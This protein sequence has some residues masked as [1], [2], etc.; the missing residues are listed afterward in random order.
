MRGR[1][2]ARLDSSSSARLTRFAKRNET[3]RTGLSMYT[4]YVLKSINYQ[5]TY[6]GF[7]A[8]LE[9]RVKEHNAGK[10]TYT[11]RYAPL[12]VVLN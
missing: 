8:N 12:L 3:S 7:T 5:K 10:S 11:S 1:L 2:T 9:Q 4:I 6:I